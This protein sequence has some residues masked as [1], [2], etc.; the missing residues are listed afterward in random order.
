MIPETIILTRMER[1]VQERKGVH[2]RV[3]VGA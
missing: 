3:D 1:W 2:S